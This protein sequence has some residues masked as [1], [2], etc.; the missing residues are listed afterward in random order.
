MIRLRLTHGLSHSNGFVSATWRNPEVTVDD[1]AAARYCVD[2]G[3]FEII[4]RDGDSEPG[5]N[6]VQEPP[7]TSLGANTSD[8]EN[9][10]HE[11]A[12]PGQGD[13]DGDQEDMEGM[14]VN[15]LKA[16]AVTVGIDLGKAIKKS[17]IIAIIRKAEA[18]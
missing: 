15:E 4:G 16:Y 3:F 8:A 2:S 5:Q 12:A 7:E 11:P 9:A 10:P 18:E 13:S 1:E 17:D 14:T 6:G